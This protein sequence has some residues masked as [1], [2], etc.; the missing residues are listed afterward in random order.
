MISSDGKGK[1]LTDPNLIHVSQPLAGRRHQNLRKLRCC[2]DFSTT[3]YLAVS[4][5]HVLLPLLNSQPSLEEL[6][7]K[8]KDIHVMPP[9]FFWRDQKRYILLRCKRTHTI[10]SCKEKHRYSFGQTAAAP[11]TQKK[12]GDLRMTFTADLTTY[13][14]TIHSEGLGSLLR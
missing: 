8:S 5:R 7:I 1:K 4:R 11:T 2:I 12:P 9:L 13:S 6:N 3:P 14:A 10:L